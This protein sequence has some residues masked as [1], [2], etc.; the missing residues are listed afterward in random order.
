MKPYFA[1]HRFYLLKEFFE[2]IFL[3]SDFFTSLSWQNMLSPREQGQSLFQTLVNMCCIKTY[4][5]LSPILNFNGNAL[6][7]FLF[8]SLI[9]FSN[10]YDIW[11]D[12]KAQRFSANANSKRIIW[13]YVILPYNIWSIHKTLAVRTNIFVSM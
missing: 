4:S 9:E 1:R 5:K 13:T 10:F 12:F 6:L 8:T 7:T 11:I 2:D 3:E